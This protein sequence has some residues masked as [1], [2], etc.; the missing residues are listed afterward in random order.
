[1][2]SINITDSFGLLASCLSALAAITALWISLWVANVQRRIQEK[3]LKQDLFD[4]RYAVYLAVGEFLM[5]VV[6]VDGSIKLPSDEY[7]TFA[8]TMEQAEFLFGS[9]VNT[10]LRDMK[11]KALALYPK[12]FERDHLARMN[13]QNADLSLEIS[14]VIGDLS[15]PDF[16]KRK[17]IFGPYLKL[18]HSEAVAGDVTQMKMNGWQR[19]WV[20]VAILWI[21][22]VLVF[23][24]ELWPTTADIL[25]GDVY[26][27]MK[28]DDGKRLADY[29]DVVMTQLGSTSIPNPIIIKLQQDK[30][31]LTASSKDQKAYLSHIDPNFAKASPL[32]QDSYLA[33]I[34]GVTGPSAKIDSYTLQF[35]PG[36]PQED[37]DKTVG[38][39][40]AAL[41]RVLSLKRVIFG[42]ESFA[43]WIV[44]AIALYVIGLGIAWVRRGFGEAH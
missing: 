17:Q 43:W 6:R 15:G 4:K 8:Y 5:H 1:V 40:R 11:T 12:C 18:S 36:V 27:K 14:K 3:Q 32:D 13:Q 31:F 23:S 42:S 39:Y 25:K 29:Y 38:E 9:D 24:Y 7:R 2:A 10:Y 26:M 33:N 37:Q 44:P 28:P 16:D 35:V 21:L 20:V 34:T 30:D 19:L 41:R 22:P